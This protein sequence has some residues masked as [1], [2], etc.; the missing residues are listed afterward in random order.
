MLRPI[1]SLPS[2]Q[3]FECDVWWIQE[4]AHSAHMMLTKRCIEVVASAEAI[5]PLAE[6]DG[7]IGP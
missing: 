1:T 2:P 5:A 3:I 6:N 4:V 7:F